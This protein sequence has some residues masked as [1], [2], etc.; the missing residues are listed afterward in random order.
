MT[1]S[2]AYGAKPGAAY[3]SGRP[4]DWPPD[5]PPPDEDDDPLPPG[6]PKPIPP[7]ESYSLTLTA[8]ATT[9]P[10]K[11][12]NTV[13]AEVFNTSGDNP[14]P[15]SELLNHGIRLTAVLYDTGE[16]KQVWLRRAGTTE[17]SNRLLYLVNPLSDGINY[18]FE[19]DIEVWLD[20][21]H[22]SLTITFTAV[23]FTLDAG[24][25]GT[26]TSGSLIGAPCDD[27]PSDCT[28]CC[29]TKWLDWVEGL[30][31]EGLHAGF[32]CHE[33]PEAENSSYV[34]AKTGCE[35]A[36]QKFC[37]TKGTVEGYELTMKCV[38]RFWYIYSAVDFDNPQDHDIVAR[39]PNT[40]DCPPLAAT[41]WEFYAHK[42]L[43]ER[44]T[45]AIMSC[46][47]CNPANCAGWPAAI[48]VTISGLTGTELCGT[49]ED[50]IEGNGAH[51]LAYN[52]GVYDCNWEGLIIGGYYHI[53]LTCEDGVWY[54]FGVSNTQ[55]NTA[56]WAFRYQGDFPSGP[57][58]TGWEWY[59]GLVP[60]LANPPH[61]P[62]TA[63]QAT[64]D[65]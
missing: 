11:D 46:L 28:A 57:P 2:K 64:L 43:G 44:L 35:Y 1:K 38:G 30:D 15:A 24:P 25:S 18:G 54:L 27:C 52:D 51:A 29:G 21:R 45:T 26:D 23:L 5:A 14:I 19:E 34:F 22:D 63:A 41:E 32:N 13:K 4:D 55:S 17:W 37:P 8:P 49:V 65:Y 6:W 60:R 7:T 56:C 40:N 16:Y 58:K 62:G 3:D 47:D 36:G 50:C 33:N 61:C 12:D 20:G 10:C 31:E 48:T 53:F 59:T 9:Y 39:S 42:T